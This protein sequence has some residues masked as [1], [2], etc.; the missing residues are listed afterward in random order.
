MSTV[1]VVDE[2]FLAV[3]PARVAAQFAEPGSWPR[4][5]PDLRLTVDEPAD[6]ELV[7]RV[8]ETLYPVQPDFGIAETLTLLRQNPDW[9]LLNSAVRQKQPS[10]G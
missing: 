5:W 4:Y 7:R 1:D 6:F 3:P 2:T 8:F 9:V 10:E